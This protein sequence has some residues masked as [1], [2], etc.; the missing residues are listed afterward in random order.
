MSGI[1]A[2]E[3]IDRRKFERVVR[4]QTNICKRRL[5]SQFY[6]MGHL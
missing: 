1:N 6:K 2:L 4:Q 5:M 3:T